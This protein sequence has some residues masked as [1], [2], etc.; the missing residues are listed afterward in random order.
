MLKMRGKGK[1]K[2]LK[3]L[4]CECIK[5]V[6][7]KRASESIAIP[8]CIKS[9]LHTRKKTIKSFKCTGKDSYLKTQKHRAKQSRRAKIN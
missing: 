6:S 5:S 4:L 3:R 8:I 9:V 2:T 7:K 1:R